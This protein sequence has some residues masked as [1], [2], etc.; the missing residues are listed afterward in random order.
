MNS[1]SDNEVIEGIGRSSLRTKENSVNYMLFHRE[2][3][4]IFS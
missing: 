4:I 1:L 2:S 3:P